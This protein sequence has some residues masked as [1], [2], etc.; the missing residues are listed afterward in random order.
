MDNNE[1][2]LTFGIMIAPVPPWKQIV[3]QA[4]LVEKLGFDKIWLPDH[5]VNSQN[6]EMDW[7]DGWST[8]TALATQTETIQLGTMVSSMTLRNPA[9]LARMALSADHISGGRLELGV[10]AGGTI[11]CHLMTGIPQWE[12]RER[13]A[14]YKEFI[15]ILDHMLTEKVTTYAGKYYNIQGALLRP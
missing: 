7:L 13:S 12:P 10:G 9:V 6:K 14:R 2:N 4:R 3:G 15:E 1:A 11:N 8:L 5:F